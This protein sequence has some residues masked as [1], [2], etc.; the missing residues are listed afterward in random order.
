[1]SKIA[2]CLLIL[3]MAACV[4][5]AQPKRQVRAVWLT[6]AYGLDWP[7][8]PAGQKAQLDKILDTLSDLNVNVV[9][10]QCRIRGDVVYRSAYEPLN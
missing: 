1:M 2:T 4:A 8:S 3:L 7:Q 10:F 9:M 6:T 5:V